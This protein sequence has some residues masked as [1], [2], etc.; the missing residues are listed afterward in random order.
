[1]IRIIVTNMSQVSKYPIK[2]EIADR[3]FEILIKTLIKVRDKEEA[4]HLAEDLFTPAE[5]IMLA[6]RLAIAFLLMKGYQYRNISQL[7]RVSL[8]TIASVNLSINNGRNGYKAILERI[9]NEERLDEFFKNMIDSVVSVPA[10]STKGRG[11]WKYLREEVSK[12]NRK[13]AF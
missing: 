13:K 12:N 2:K 10:G 6:K 9:K 8:G 3:I 11:T 5:K 1:M 7:L 4:N